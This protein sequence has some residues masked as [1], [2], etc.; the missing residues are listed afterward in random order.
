M[1]R[2]G[3]IGIFDV[4][5]R[6]RERYPVVYGAHMKVEDGQRVQ[7]RDVLLEWDPFAN[8]ILT[9]V[10]GTH[11]VRRHHRGRRPCRSRST[12]SP[13]CPRG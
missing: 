1:N 7:A 5:G 11:Q 13:A 10:G 8:P 2:N 3:E 6:E 9:E 4:S 12:S